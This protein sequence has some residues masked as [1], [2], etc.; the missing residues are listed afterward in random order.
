MGVA[1]RFPAYRGKSGGVTGMKN[2]ELQ[3]RLRTAREFGLEPER[4]TTN[5]EKT[6]ARA[7][8]AETVATHNG[9]SN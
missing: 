4:V 3:P 6:L 9:F 7:R 8:H 2:L 1:Q 5:A